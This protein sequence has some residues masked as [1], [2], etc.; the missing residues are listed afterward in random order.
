[1]KYLFPLFSALVFLV[2]CNSEGRKSTSPSVSG[3]KDD[4]ISDIDNN[5]DPDE[6]IETVDSDV[7][8]DSLDC[9]P[10]DEAPFPYID[11][12]GRKHFC[13]KCDK[14]KD[15]DPQCVLNL[16]KNIN[17]MLYE[18]FP[19]K[20]CYPYP[21]D[22]ED[23]N[24]PLTAEKD[25]EWKDVLS[26]CDKAITGFGMNGYAFFPKTFLSNGKVGI[27]LSQGLDPEGKDF[28][29]VEYDILKNKYYA[30]S[31]CG[32]EAGYGYERFI[33]YVGNAIDYRT[34]VISA[35]GK[36]GKYHFEMIYT[37]DDNQVSFINPPAVGKNWVVL[38]IDH[39]KEKK[40]ET[41][42]ARVGE[43]KWKPIGDGNFD[44]SYIIGDTFYFHDRLISY[45]CDLSK[46]PTIP[47]EHCRQ[48]N[49]P[50]EKGGRPTPDLDNP[51]RI[52]YAA[53]EYGTSLVEVDISGKENKYK[54]LYIKP[55]N[56]ARKYYPDQLRG[57][58]LVYT[59]SR[60]K[61]A[62]AADLRICFYRTDLAEKFCTVIEENYP[63]P[64]VIQSYP[65]LEGYNLVFQQGRAHSILRDMKCYCKLY[66]ESCPFDELRD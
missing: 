30:V 54:D 10:L 22:L 4:N 14:P 20:E 36:N 59:E 51:H 2:S 48:I 57:N 65:S 47:S 6:D 26:P 7:D 49:R 21:C 42:Y 43:W 63:Y 52:I 66:Q 11:K 37:D 60:T 35:S 50:N 8:Y 45:A 53:G 61:S 38:S 32:T 28:K 44:K 56:E 5:E 40:K 1:M 16:T 41:I 46:G 12:N 9:P 18:K 24:R 17:K 58:L 31:R 39:I 27:F 15:W 62:G 55:D 13:R 33:F 25:P 29:M 23:K 64:T 34:Y 19:D 3:Q